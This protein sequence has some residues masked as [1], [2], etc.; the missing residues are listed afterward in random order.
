MNKAIKVAAVVLALVLSFSCF[1]CNK[2]AETE[3]T[4]KPD[5]NQVNLGGATVRV[6]SP[7]IKAGT[8]EEMYKD[9]G[10]EGS[11][12]IERCHEIETIF[13]CKIEY[14]GEGTGYGDW[15]K[16]RQGILMEDPYADI[17]PVG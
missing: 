3:Q 12:I 5:P 11:L 15:D 9:L 14:V 2:N 1:G 17:A 16:L 7:G 4:K 6:L 10:S 8:P 13:N